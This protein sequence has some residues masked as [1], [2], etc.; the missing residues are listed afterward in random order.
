MNPPSPH[1]R[2]EHLRRE[3]ERHSRLYYEDAAPE[4]S[5]RDFDRLMEELI[6]LEHEHPELASPDSP[7]RRVGG[8]PLQQF[9][10]VDHLLPMLS[11]D[12][13]YNLDELREFHRRVVKLA[14]RDD[15]T[16]VVEP[17]IDGVS[18]S[19]RYQN[20][21]LTLGATR[22]NGTT[23]DDITQNLKTLHTLPLRLTLP[24][25]PELLEVRGEAYLPREGF[26]KLNREREAAGEPLFANPRNA[27]AGSLKQLDPAIVAKRPLAAVCYAVG[28]TRGITFTHHHQEIETLRH[29][30]FTIPHLWWTCS[31]IDDVIA[32][33]EELQRHEHDLPYDIDGAVI[34]LDELALWTKLGSTAKAPR[35]AIA[36][37]YSHEQ[38][39]TLLRAITVQV[40]R[41]GTLTPVAE[42]D[43]VLLAGSTISRATL[44]NEEEIRR[45]DIRIGDTVIIEK[46][47]QVIPAVIHVVPS[48][49]PPHAPPFDL[50]A[51]VGGICPA[52]GGPI[53]RDPEFVAW[54]CENIS[55]PAQIKRAIGHFAGRTAMDIE[56]L[57]EALIN[58]LV[59]KRLVAN[60][61]DLYTLTAPQL[62]SLERMGEKS[63]ANLIHAIDH[64]RGRDLWRLLHGLGIPHVGEGS[65]RRLARAF[66]SL[67][68]IL[69][70]TPEQLQAVP[71]IGA[72]MAEAIHEF[73]TNPK[74]LDLCRSL[75]TAGLNT[76]DLAPPPPATS[77][78]FTGKTIVVTGTLPSY[79]RDTI[80]EKLRTL[81]ATITDSV[82]KNTHYL[83][84]GEAAGSKLAKAQKLGIPVL[85]EAAFHA[86]IE[87]SSRPH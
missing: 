11:L 66:G 75:A 59:E 76:R 24:N 23:G 27:T 2:I 33:V 60:L 44:H 68:A 69:N 61:A 34:K 37:K 74:N 32:R 77:S 64:S 85:D 47:G 7:S 17:K 87:P 43:P 82:S 15:L 48:L 42:L 49:R 3:I 29:A 22:G 78:P 14:A 1:P 4:I 21:L 53:H 40:G 83:L 54:R 79:T 81:G 56:G 8:A 58:Q 31:G 65:A 9:Q 84:A 73:F 36:Y 62:Q 19:L 12:N 63:A 30:G 72:I 52:C 55:C 57:G 46:A 86:L 71:D 25:P 38:A 50:F 6:R 70:A 45:K 39:Q 10:S 67:D 13:T 26:A 41:T 80:K 5:D 28:A 20:G 18:I 51:H 35:F 16:Y